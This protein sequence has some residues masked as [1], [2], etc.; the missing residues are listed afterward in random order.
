M[1]WRIGDITV[2]R[3]VDM[4]EPHADGA[5]LM[6][7]ATREAVAAIDWL[8]PNFADEE[9]NIK[10]SFHAFV[11]ETPSVTI[12]VDTCIGSDKDRGGGPM[13]KLK[14]PF[15]ENLAAAGFSPEDIDVVL[16]THLHIDHV[17]W[18]T[19]LVDGRWVPTFPKA[20]YLMGRTEF[21]FWRDQEFDQLHQLV[22]DDSVRPV[23]EAG[24]V[25]LVETDHKICEEARLVSTPGHTP[26]H[27]SVELESK[28]ERAF[29]TGDMAH[30]PCQLAHPE[31][32]TNFDSD[33]SQSTDT[34]RRVFAELA[35]KPVLVLG[36]HFAEPTAGRI[37]RDGDAFRLKT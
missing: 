21:D 8:R 23:F 19:R 3:I 25:D 11:V 34:R 20:R 32:A 13:D 17:G 36:T 31:W 29:I 15:L 5:F 18:N 16:C 10:M 1:K 14:T 37:V 27:V 24:L 28:N 22:F 33:K 7:D 4:E 35:G 9:G 6:P 26:G 2:T 30:H 12:M